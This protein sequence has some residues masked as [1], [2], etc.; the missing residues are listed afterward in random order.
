MILVEAWVELFEF[1]N[2]AKAFMLQKK[3][4]NAKYSSAVCN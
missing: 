1:I 4:V 2:T 3:P